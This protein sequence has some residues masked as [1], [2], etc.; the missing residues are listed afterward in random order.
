MTPLVISQKIIIIKQLF[1][2]NTEH[3]KKKY[4]K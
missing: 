2:E 3:M 4:R 1:Q